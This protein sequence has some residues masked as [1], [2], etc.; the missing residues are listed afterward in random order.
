[1]RPQLKTILVVSMLSFLSGDLFANGGGY[2]TGGTERTG[3]IAGFEPKATESIRMAEEDLH[4]KLGPGRAKVEIRYRMENVTKQRVSVRFGFPVEES[5]KVHG[6]GIGAV[7]PPAEEIKLHP[8]PLYCQGYRIFDGQREV[9]A[10][11]QAEKRSALDDRFAHLAGWF[12]SEVSFAPAEVKEWMIRFESTYPFKKSTVSDDEFVSAARFKYRLS[13]AA[14]WS[15]TIGKGRIVLEPDG[16]DPDELQVIKPVNRFQKSGGQWVWEFSDLEPTLADDIE[17]EA[18]PEISRYSSYGEASDPNELGYEGR[19]PRWSIIHANY[20]VTAS[21]ILPAEGER[22]YGPG[23]LK[24]WGRPW[25]E[26]ASGSGVGEWLEIKPRV[27]KQLSAITFSP[28]FPEKSLFK[29]NARPKRVRV[30]LNGEHVITTEIE[31]GMATVRIPVSGY[32]KPVSIIRL[33]FEDVWPGE[34]FEDLC[35]H[36]LRLHVRVDRKPRFQPAR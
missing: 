3:D 17:V 26:G 36:T 5:P 11:W 9:K 18:Q 16:I 13:T 33:T 10:K 12:V 6:L 23:N 7:L 29:A 25:A 30:E 31:D 27:A 8:E 35:L 2:V 32:V 34:Q 1:M 28:G 22:S 14:C 24:E 21:S 19:G 15:G 4:I 20:E